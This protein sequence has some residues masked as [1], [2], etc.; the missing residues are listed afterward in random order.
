MLLVGE[1]SNH[2]RTLLFWISFRVV[3]VGTGATHEP[4]PQ[5]R[6]EATQGSH[7]DPGGSTART[8]AHLEAH[9][10]HTHSPTPHQRRPD[11]RQPQAAECH[12]N[13]QK[14][15]HTQE[16][17]TQRDRALKHGFSS[18][19]RHRRRPRA[20]GTRKPG[21]GSGHTG[22]TVKRLTRRPLNR[23]AARC[24]LTGTRCRLTG[25]PLGRQRGSEG[26]GRVVVGGWGRHGSRRRQTT[27]PARQ[28]HALP[29]GGTSDCRGEGASI[30]SR[31]GAARPGEALSDRL[32]EPPHPLLHVIALGVQ[33]SRACIDSVSA[34]AV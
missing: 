16:S 27:T 5:T 21:A 6:E 4:R 32:P 33:R 29:P 34:R 25:T 18:R 17:H 12:R 19:H 30:A 1:I 14:D 15:G 7:R 23:R 28:Q 26:G 22:E 13:T 31:E 8:E 20:R 3:S 24:R 9:K 2:S 11:T 10:T